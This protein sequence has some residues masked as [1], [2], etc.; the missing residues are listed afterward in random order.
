MPSGYWMAF[1][2]M[3]GLPSD[4]VTCLDAISDGTGS[5]L[6][7]ENT[8][9][10]LSDAAIEATD[11]VPVK[12]EQP[13]FLV[14]AGTEDRGFILIRDDI[15]T[16]YDR[17]STGGVLPSDSI[18]DLAFVK[19]A[20]FTKLA[21]A[22]SAGPAVLDIM[23]STLTSPTTPDEAGHLFSAVGVRGVSVLFGSDRALWD[24]ESSSLT[25]LGAD[26]FPAHM[27]GGMSSAE[28]LSIMDNGKGGFYVGF[29]DGLTSW[30][31][32]IK[33]V[34]IPGIGDSP[35]ISS[36]ANTKKYLALAS[37]K[38]LLLT[39]S[40]NWY[41]MDA[42]SGLPAD[43]V[44]AVS[45]TEKFRIEGIKTQIKSL[46]D[47][48]PISFAGQ[49]VG[50][51]AILKKKRK[52]LEDRR[53]EMLTMRNQIM[54][55]MEINEELEGRYA[56]LFKEFQDDMKALKKLEEAVEN[57]YS[58]WVGT[59]RN[60]LALAFQGQ[61]VSLN[62]ENAPL[63]SDSITEIK[64][65]EK[66]GT[67][68]FGTLGGGV[69]KFMRRGIFFSNPKPLKV[70]SGRVSRIR[71]RGGRLHC[72]TDR[73]GVYVYDFAA[74]KGFRLFDRMKGKEAL[75]NMTV[76]ATDLDFDDEG[77]L[78]ASIYGIGL[79]G[80]S[81]G[82][83]FLVNEEKGLP[84]LKLTAVHCA[85]S[86]SVWVGME[87]G[88]P[89]SDRVLRYENGQIL[90]FDSAWLDTFARLSPE[91]FRA[92]VTDQTLSSHLGELLGAY[93]DTE[94]KYDSTLIG[95][96]KVTSILQTDDFP[97]FATAGRGLALLKDGRFHQVAPNK[98]VTTETIQM[99]GSDRGKRI[100]VAAANQAFLHDGAAWKGFPL[101]PGMTRG[102]VMVIKTDPANPEAIWV[103]GSDN[104]GKGIAVCIPPDD[105][106]VSVE[107]PEKVL[108]I[109]SDSRHLFVGT[110]A[111]LYIVKLR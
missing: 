35:Y 107:L 34:E 79:V 69:M 83:L 80:V 64:Y 15:I 84:N 47:G 87:G 2:T 5:L 89:M 4:R 78:F 93:M 99:V 81:N 17:E 12:A 102:K 108:D 91:Q 39:D 31:G 43:W 57:S 13:G 33:R 7:D 62:T 25:R 50:D 56:V 105:E 96:S 8:G 36:M 38:G 92:R 101:P 23:S 111:G 65:F 97:L 86:G 55:S 6:D 42:S 104:N 95:T 3:D 30:D 49:G 103:G 46:D 90:R 21:I 53:A 61:M 63:T 51:A 1:T 19:M 29:A 20:G 71:A 9:G 58:L 75:G 48:Q 67:G 109:Y 26:G 44:T 40:L 28:A 22:T 24:M 16:V 72:A 73:D 110:E 41:A 66:A 68:W 85:G 74:R 88:G 11:E 106:V 52:Q 27:A 70:Y 18:R 14:A 82:S 59:Q 45:M 77:N 94:N 32:S 54:S 100:L 10:E 37:V 76:N 98:S 60:G